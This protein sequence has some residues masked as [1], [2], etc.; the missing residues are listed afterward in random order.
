MTQQ[1]ADAIDAELDG[2]EAWEEYCEWWAEF[3]EAE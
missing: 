1:Q 2:E 3:G